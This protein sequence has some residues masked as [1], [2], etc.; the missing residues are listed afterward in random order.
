MAVTCEDI[1]NR[2][3]QML[4]FLE[5]KAAGQLDGSL[6]SFGR[7]FHIHTVSP[8]EIRQTVQQLIEIHSPPRLDTLSVA[9]W[10]SAH[11]SCSAYLLRIVEPA[12]V[13]VRSCR[14]KAEDLVRL[15]RDLIGL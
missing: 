3:A 12:D 9:E 11:R 5:E 15:L 6:F 13:V 7:C 4:R 1:A 10:Q 2:S 8:G 14:H